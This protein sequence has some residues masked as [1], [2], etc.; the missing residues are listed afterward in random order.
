MIAAVFSGAAIYINCVEQPA[1]LRLENAALLKQWKVAYK[2]GAVMQ[3]SLALLASICGIISFLKDFNWWCLMGSFFIL[4][5]WPY[6]LMAILPVNQKIMAT[7]ENEANEQ[8]RN[9]ITRWGF[10]HAIRSLLGIM[11][12]LCFLIA[13]FFSSQHFLITHAR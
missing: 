4:A 13:S 7:S 5:N 2:K 3:V 12:T 10:L 9:L 1:R 6:T 8:T 11:A